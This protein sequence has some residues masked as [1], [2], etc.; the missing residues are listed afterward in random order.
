VGWEVEVEGEKGTE[1]VKGEEG[2]SGAEVRKE[3]TL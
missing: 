3:G 2:D 1:K